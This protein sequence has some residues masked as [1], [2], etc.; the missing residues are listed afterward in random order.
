V[1]ALLTTHSM[2]ETTRW[3][4]VRSLAG[5]WFGVLVVAGVLLVAAGGYATATAH[6]VP[7]TTTDTERVTHWQVERE[8]SHSA[9]VTRENPVFKVGETLRDRTAYFVAA[10]PVLNVTHT[11]TYRD[12]GDRDGPA[13]LSVNASLVVTSTAEGR[14]LWTNQTR[15]AATEATVEPGDSTVVHAAV[16]T[17]RVRQRIASIRRSLGDAAGEVSTAVVVSTAATTDSG[18]TASAD[19]RLPLTL[20]A[21]AYEVGS[22]QPATASATTT[23]PVTVTRSYGPLWRVGGPVLCLL[24]AALLG[25][26]YAGRRADALG[27]TAAEREYLAYRDDRAEFA[28]W[29]VR[30][31]LPASVHDR[32]TATAESLSDLVDYAIDAD[33]GVVEDTATETYVVTTP[34]LVVVYEPPRAP[35]SPE[36]GE[37]TSFE[38][39]VTGDT[40]QRDEDG[41]GDESEQ[42]PAAAPEQA[43]ADRED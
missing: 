37:L 30:A 28:E 12:L 11:A 5:E 39:D 24:G 33:A 27:L 8:F 1:G 14:V 23:R 18:R 17:T 15:L 40:G 36:R 35:D 2:G 4:R 13:T 42:T 16:N 29:I 3:L 6:A 25:G 10:T 26:L 22:T 32:E 43:G 20:G 38:F 7:G 21:A 31:R 34:G 41:D 9:T 19:H